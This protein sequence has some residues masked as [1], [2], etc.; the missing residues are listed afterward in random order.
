MFQ[1][2]DTGSPKILVV[3][4]PVKLAT[5]VIVVTVF[6]KPAIVVIALHMITFVP[7]VN[8]HAWEG[9]KI[10]EVVMGQCSAV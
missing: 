8:V 6:E 7:L 1:K 5:G 4:V 3:T 10:S 2:K 9:K